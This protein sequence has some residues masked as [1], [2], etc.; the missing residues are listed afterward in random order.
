MMIWAYFYIIYILT[1]TKLLLFR[2][3]Y[4]YYDIIDIFCKI[5]N[6]IENK[7]RIYMIYI[8]LL[9]RKI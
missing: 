5:T 9:S 4:I 1:F 6:P 2:I 3:C 8:N 7:V